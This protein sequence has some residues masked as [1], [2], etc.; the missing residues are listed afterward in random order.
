MLSF[1]EFSRTW[2]DAQV[3]SRDTGMARM[4]GANPYP[5][6]DDIGSI[7]FLFQ[8]VVDGRLAPKE[9]VLAFADGDEAMAFPFSE[10]R[11]ANFAQATVGE[12]PVVVFWDPG[13]R[14]PLNRE[15]VEGYDIGAVGGFDRR[16]DGRTLTFRR[17][18]ALVLD[19]ETGSTWTLSGTASDG[20]LK[21]RR[22]TPLVYSEPFWFAWAA[23]RPDT[24]IWTAP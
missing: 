11:R 15:D 7:P 20:P 12:T 6:Y 19:V 10:L 16:L 22:L 18:G 3:L 1:R 21:G 24:T 23:F 17:D 9:R 13:V 2:P 8:G 5:G 4:Y 14:S